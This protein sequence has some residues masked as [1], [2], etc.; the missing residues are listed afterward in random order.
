MHQAELLEMPVPV[1]GKEPK[2][3]NK[4]PP[5]PKV[6][7]LA[8]LI[9]P[10]LPKVFPF[11]PLAFALD[12]ARKFGDIAY[13]CVGPLR[14]YQ[15]NCPE[16][17]RQILVEHPEQFHKPVFIKRGFGPFV[18][19]GLLTSDGDLW[20]QHRKLMQPAFN[21]TQIG[22]YADIMVTHASRLANS[23]QDGE[24]RD[25]SSDMAKLTLGVLIKSLFG[26]DFTRQA[27]EIGTLMT[28]VLEAANQRL[29]SALQIPTWVPTR[30]N[31]HE[32]RALARIETMLR[33]LI[34]ERRTSNEQWNDLLSVLLKA[35]DEESGARM[36]DRQLR[37][38][39]MTLFLAG[40]ETT[41]NALTWTWY[42]LAQHP[43][44]AAKLN[45]EIRR[46]LGGRTPSAGDLHLL[47]Y[48]E[49]VLR[50][51]LRLY[52]A[53]PGFAREPIEDVQ[54]GGY[55]IPKGSLIAVNTWALHRDPKLFEGPERFDPDRFAP[56][57]EA[58]IPRYAYLPFGG[59]PRVCI[60]NGFAMM[61]ARLIIA[62]LAQRWQFTL[63]PDQDIIPVQLVTLRP[64]NGIRV[65]IRAGELQTVMPCVS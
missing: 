33:D 20:K 26:A 5:G 10:M 29:I 15:V 55:E 46:M 28:A 50:E 54:I 8:A 3:A 13:Y 21:H 58:R 51:S 31:I 24:V 34:E 32:R 4:N 60:G 22:K 2:L 1:E 12:N 27:E 44:V 57:W 48:T 41:A 9:G 63:E 61:E 65:K 43:D 35:V 19:N 49:M 45:D 11:D 23:F 6:N 59:G 56:G 40:H 14:V 37:D 47:P 39:M 7:F 62:T 25:I 38:E 53:A 30:R 36:S 52:P 16:L 18:G 42:M 17:I 64:K